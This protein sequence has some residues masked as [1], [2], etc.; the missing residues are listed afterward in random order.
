M[1][2]PGMRQS[3]FK[4]MQWTMGGRLLKSAM[5]IGTLVVVSRYLGPAEFGL[6]ALVMFVIGFGQLFVDAGLRV[7]LVQRAEITELQKNTVFWSSLAF[8]LLLAGL[9]I[10]FAAPIARAFDAETIEPLVRWMTVVF[11]LAAL[12]GVSTTVLERRF[13]FDRIAISEVVAA[14]AGAA[15][16]IG[17]VVA[18]YGIAALVMQQLV[19]AAISCVIQVAM[20]RWRPRLE[21]SWQ[22]FRG[23][24][25][26]A[27]Y[28]LMTD[29]VS[30]LTTQLDRPL[31]SGLFNPQTLGYL[32][33]SRQIVTSPFKIFAQMARKVLFPMLASVQHDRARVGAA[34]LNIQFAMVLLMAPV[35]LGVAAIA[36]P[37]VGLLL[38][39]KWAP[40]VP[41]IQLLSVQMLLLPVQ[42]VNQTVLTSLGFAKFQFYWQLIAGS[43]SLGA[44]VLAAPWGIE[45]AV[46]AR[47]AVTLF[48]MPLLSA[49]T[50]RQMDLPRRALAK[51]VFAPFAAGITMY[52]AVSGTAA[53]LSLPDIAVLA[54]CIPLGMAVYV[55]LVFLLERRRTME[56]FRLVRK[57]G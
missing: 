44:M 53:W 55:P 33:M 9:F 48:T 34:Y 16:A 4:S 38:G 22:D 13:A 51:A 54:I 29:I 28:V 30:F 47:V 36:V 20:A 31:V 14:V 8:A 39:E 45:A 21:F 24:M 27:A 49:Y 46:G 7:A 18:G 56:I 43:V 32:T 25:S 42:N 41:L 50:M 57:R 1:T 19:Q 40:V 3:A 10:L 23:L 15:T 2:Q 17:L 6:V 12:Q 5:G 26:Y 11:I 52:L 35:C 37:M